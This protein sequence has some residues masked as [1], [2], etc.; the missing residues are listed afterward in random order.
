M[1]KGF[2]LN[3]L[4][5]SG[6][7]PNGFS[8]AVRLA[9]FAHSDTTSLP[10]SMILITDQVLDAAAVQRRLGSV[11]AGASVVFTGTTRR[12][13]D[14]RE[15]VDL[16]YECYRELAEKALRDLE[17]TARTR[18]RLVECV[19]LHRIGLVPLGEA[20]VVVGV[21]AAHRDEAF[22]SAR[23]LIDTLKEQVP[24]WKQEHWADGT[25]QWIHP[26]MSPPQAAPGGDRNAG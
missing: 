19:L 1:L 22:E 2:L 8:C 24:I 23:W 26:G 21:S 7:L 16:T 12:L 11:E 15:T 9:V 13:T 6:F 3:G 18:W 4:L 25:R 20:S 10:N 17:S 5:P 14:G